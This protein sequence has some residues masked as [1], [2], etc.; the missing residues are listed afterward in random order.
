MRGTSGAIGIGIAVLLGVAGNAAGSGFNL[1]EAGARGTALG[2]AFTA[3]ADDGSA[4][5]YNPAGIAFLEGTTIDL[6]IVPVIPD[7]KFTGA[8]LPHATG[9]PPRGQT[10]SKVFPLPGIYVTRQVATDLRL[11]IGFYAPFGLGVEWKNPEEW[12]GRRSSYDVDLE[13][14]YITPAAALR[15]GERAAISIGLDLAWSAIELKRYSAIEFGPTAELVDVLD[16]KLEGNS[17]LNVTPCGGVLVHITDKLSLG[18]MYH[19]PKTLRFDDGDATL[20][21]VAPAALAAT[22]DQQLA[23]MGGAN[24]KVRTRLKL[25]WILSLGVGY[26]IHERAH[27]E[28]DAVRFGWSNFDQLAIDFVSPT[29][30]DQ[31]IKEDYED[32]WQLRF[33]LDLDVAEGWKAMLGYIHDNTPQPIGSISPLL[34]DATREDI[35]LGVQYQTGSVRLTATYMAV[36]FQDRSN[37]VG[38]Q[39]VRFE[40][41]Q[42]AGA[43]DSVANIFGAGFGYSF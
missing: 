40:E 21:N 6:S 3:T 29:N 9:A 17:D 8:T 22:V 26:Q 35:S 10:K 2:G 28:F 5:F 12:V 33:G 25:P 42:P 16:T 1:Y 14:F 38:G 18:G 23:A 24:Q 32:I 4:L 7:A 13:T 43:Y 30:P 39:V 36:L 41:T 19:A 37:V 27:L 15:L 34:P 31:T 11:G 20:T